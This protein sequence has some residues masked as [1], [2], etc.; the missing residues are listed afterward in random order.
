[1][2]RLRPEPVAAYRI[3]IGMDYNGQRHEAGEIVTDVPLES[4]GWL[5]EQHCIE[6]VL[7]GGGE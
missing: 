4:L 6:P 1:M 5:L 7:E 2:S 3:K